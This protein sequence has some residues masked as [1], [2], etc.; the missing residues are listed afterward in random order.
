VLLAT[1]FSELEIEGFMARRTEV[2]VTDDLDGTKIP[3]GKRAPAPFALDGE[4][5]EISTST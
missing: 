3:A 2:F 4:T 5:Y 1:F